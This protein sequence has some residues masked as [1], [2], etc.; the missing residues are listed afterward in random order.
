MLAGHPWGVTTGDDAGET[1]SRPDVADA[2]EFRVVFRGGARAYVSLYPVNANSY[3]P[4]IASFTLPPLQQLPVMLPGGLVRARSDLSEL[5]AG[6]VTIRTGRRISSDGQ[7]PIFAERGGVLV[8]PDTPGFAHSWRDVAAEAS[9]G[10][11]ALESRL[12]LQR[13]QFRWTL[14]IDVVAIVAGVA[15]WS[16]GS[17]SLALRVWAYGSVLFFTSF[18]AWRRARRSQAALD[19]ARAAG[20]TPATPMHMRLWWS[21][22][23]GAGPVPVA[24]LTPAVWAAEPVE[25]QIPLA[26][27]PELPFPLTSVPVTV[28]GDPARGESPSIHWGDV[29]LWPADRTAIERAQLEDLNDE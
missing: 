29:T 10:V 21:V 1:S 12:A 26:N 25:Y 4:P 19:S 7:A 15:I 11:G 5:Y 20:D 16:S 27:V 9:Q 6:A 8:N 2:A 24:T 3:T 14:I 23:T 22:G 17:P 13:R 18:A 28:H